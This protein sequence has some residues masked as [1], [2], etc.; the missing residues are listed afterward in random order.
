MPARLTLFTFGYWGWGA[1]TK[2]LLRVTADVERERGFEPPIFVDLRIS[3]S[4]RAVGFRSS[5]FEELAG[6]ARYV[7]MKALGNRA[8]RDR[9]RSGPRIVIDDPAAAS[10]LLDLI[11]ERARHKQRIMAFCAC[12]VP[13]TSDEPICHRREVANLV[14][15]GA[16]ARRLQLDVVEWPGGEPIRRDVDV[17]GR[18]L[19]ELAHQAAFR[20]SW[21]PAEIAA[22]PWGSRITA[23]ANDASV[24]FL[25]SAARP[26]AGKLVL[27]QRAWGASSIKE[28]GAAYDDY[29]RGYGLG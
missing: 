20:P 21:P 24:T 16:R 9:S 12:E 25:T 26:R 3:R 22:V 13:G 7:W 11:V 23:R 8:V 2:L 27:P 14:L 4:V 6:P 15:A 17:S 5:T 28:W 18:E 19:G 1:A 10:T 29:V